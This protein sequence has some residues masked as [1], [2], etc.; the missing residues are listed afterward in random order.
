MIPGIGF[1]RGYSWGTLTF[2]T[3][4]EYNHEESK[5]DIGETAVEYL[6]RLSPSWR[7]FLA[8]EGG[9]GGGEDE[10]VLIPELQWCVAESMW[11]K[12]NS[13]VGITSKASDWEPEV[14]LMFVLPFA[15]E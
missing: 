8:L 4:A 10:W 7:A 11:L 5:V 15:R 9:E 14:R 3:T 1:I 12:L 2:R 13:A 6:K